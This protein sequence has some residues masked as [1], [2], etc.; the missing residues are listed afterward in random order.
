ML[1]GR[2]VADPGARSNGTNGT[3]SRRPAARWPAALAVEPALAYPSTARKDRHRGQVETTFFDRDLETLDRAS[4]KSRQEAALSRLMA[5]LGSNP[6]YRAKLADA[7]PALDAVRTLEDLSRL[8]CTSKQELVD[9]QQRRPPFGELLSYPLR[10]YRHY[11][12]TSGTSGQPLHWLDTE[13]DWETWIRCW[14]QVYRGAGVTEDDLV[15]CAFSFGPYI[16]HWTAMAGAERVGAM[17][18]SGGGMS[19]RQRLDAIVDSGATV[20]VCTPTYALHLAEIASRHGIDLAGSPVRVTIHAG[21]PGASVPN[22]KRRIEEAW[23]ARC[24]D[25]AGA[26]EV[27]AWAFDCQAPNGSIV[28]PKIRACRFDAW[29]NSRVPASAPA[30]TSWWPPRYLVALWTTTS[31]P[32]AM[33]LWL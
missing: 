7:A 21:E 26:T 2:I 25:H 6:F 19:S 28:V 13:E 5:S 20:V 27:G 14:A 1:R 16:A 9:S 12:R 3:R 22:V 4:L 24:F 17:R 23:G 11:H 31:T 32:S 18:L 10:R 30:V 15:F 8:P 29:T 33:G